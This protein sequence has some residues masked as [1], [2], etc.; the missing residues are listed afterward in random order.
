MHKT[1]NYYNIIYK[2]DAIRSIRKPKNNVRSPQQSG[3]GQS[4]V[5]EEQRT[6]PYV[7]GMAIESHLLQI[8]P[9]CKST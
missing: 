4:K 5:G 8:N 1:L 6:L 3:P 7:Q 9:K 2:L